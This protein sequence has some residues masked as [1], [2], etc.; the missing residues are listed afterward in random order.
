MDMHILKG[1]RVH[2]HEAVSV[3][4]L[5]HRG[6]DMPVF[7]SYKEHEPAVGMVT[8]DIYDKKVYASGKMPQYYIDL[9]ESG[10][11]ILGASVQVSDGIAQ[12]TSVSL[13]NASKANII[14]QADEPE[15]GPDLKKSIQL[16][17]EAGVK[18][19][20]AVRALKRAMELMPDECVQIIDDELKRRGLK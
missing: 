8:L 10:S 7:D 2:L 14:E 11:V 18:A 5:Y 17:A 15:D 16:I 19:E 3:E 4:Q 6:G 13:V 12:I 20:D 1:I 9:L